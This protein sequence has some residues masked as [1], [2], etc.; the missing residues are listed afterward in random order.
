ML[1]TK[2]LAKMLSELKSLMQTD[3]CSDFRIMLMFLD[4]NSTNCDGIVFLEILTFVRFEQAP[5]QHCHWRR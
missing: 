1:S 4:A 3:I 2:V 5:M